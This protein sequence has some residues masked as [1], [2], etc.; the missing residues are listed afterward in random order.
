MS[1]PLVFE[2]A[3]PRY[4]LPFLYSGQAQKEFYVNEAFAITDAI[5]HCAIEGT[6]ATPPTSPADGMNW[7]VA[8]G[9]TGDWSGQVG[10]IACRQSGGWL[11]VTPRDGMHV[12]DRSSGR[13]LLYAAGWQIPSPV[14]PPTG[15]TTIDTEA[16]KAV[17]QLINA[18]K[19]AGILP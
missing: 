1:D 9:A 8:P 10:K 15:G 4:S 7:C 3:S 17:N 11:F 5:L 18:L 13:T 2:N 16:R 19:L 6:S 12:F 14:T